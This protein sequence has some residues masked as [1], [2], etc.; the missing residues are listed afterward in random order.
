[1]DFLH[2]FIIFLLSLSLLQTAIKSQDHQL[3]M[4][5][6]KL[7]A[8][9]QELKLQ[10]TSN[11]HQELIED[12]RYSIVEENEELKSA[13]FDLP[14]NN[15][16]FTLNGGDDPLNAMGVTRFSLRQRNYIPPPPPRD[17]GAAQSIE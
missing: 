10:K 4:Q 16:F 15:N 9:I 5:L 8:E 6:M 3:A 11:E 2:N 14:M 13:L 7:R 12:A 1:M 17:M